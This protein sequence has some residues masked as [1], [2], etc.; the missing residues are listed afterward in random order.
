M[1][2]V[3]MAD[4]KGSRWN[5]YMGLTK[6]NIRIGGETLLERTVRLL[7]EYDAA[8]EVIIT[9]HNTQLH[10][11]GAERYEPKNNVLEIDRFTAELIGDDMCFLY[12][13]VYYSEEAIKT[14][15]ESVGAERLL[16]IGSHK[17][18]CAV[19][20]KDGA[21]FRSL[22][23]TIRSMYLDG[24]ITECKGW[25]VYHLYAGLPLESREIGRGY[26]ITDSFTRDFNSPDDYNDFI[27]GQV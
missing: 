14:I 19:L 24:R 20:I 2:Y 17:S 8:A 10:I 13:D 27:A 1:K 23:E 15:V 3:I 16:F 25:Q 26:L 21:L 7:H 12:G 22:Y 5:N 4:G 9:S 11:D 6:H 18:I